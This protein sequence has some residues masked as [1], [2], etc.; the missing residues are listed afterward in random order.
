MKLI[1]SI[2]ACCPVLDVTP[3]T[4]REAERVAGAFKVL[5]DPARIRLLSLIGAAGELCVCDLTAPLGLSQPTVSHHLKVLSDAGLLTREKRGVWVYFGVE[6]TAI[7]IL[8]K[9]LTPPARR[10]AAR[11]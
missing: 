4:K 6:P 10:A 7:D 2:E 3:V 5:A 9:A 8:R 1:Q 11:T